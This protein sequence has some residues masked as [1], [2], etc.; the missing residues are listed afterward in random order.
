MDPKQSR[1]L[2]SIAGLVLVLGFFLPWLDFGGLGVSGWYFAKNSSM[3]SMIWLIPIGGIAM[4]A[5][6]MTGSRHARLVSAVV[7]LTLVG[8]A[9]VKTV[10]S[11]F[12]T[13]GVG[14]WMVILAALGALAIPLL[15]RSEK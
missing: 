4:I 2:I 1:T 10:H 9:V 5:T 7:G 11:F 14:L 8:Y 13:T 3:S 12:A 6:A 15:S